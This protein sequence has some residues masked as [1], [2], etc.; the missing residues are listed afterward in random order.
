[1]TIPKLR[2]DFKFVTW[3]AWI[4]LFFSMSAGI[5]VPSM[6]ETINKQSAIIKE[7]ESLEPRI[8]M[9]SEMLCHYSLSK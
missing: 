2:E 9:L 7:Y 5:F 8:D 3:I 6:I 1:M 4:A